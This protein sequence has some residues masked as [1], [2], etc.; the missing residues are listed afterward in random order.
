M[1]LVTFII[2]HTNNGRKNFLLSFENIQ[3]DVFLKSETLIIASKSNLLC[4]S[5]GGKVKRLQNF[6]G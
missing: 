1:L 3:P 6:K 5:N 4:P 2:S